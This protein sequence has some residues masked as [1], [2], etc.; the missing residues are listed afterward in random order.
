[1]LQRQRL[2]QERQKLA[3]TQLL[4]RQRLEQQLARTQL[5]ERQRL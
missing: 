3:R 5:L 4:E 1:M 2:E